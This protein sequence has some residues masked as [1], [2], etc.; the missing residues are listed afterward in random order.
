MDTP[1]P[2]QVSHILCPTDFSAEA[3]HALRYAALLADAFDA[4][5]TVLHVWQLPD[6]IRPDLS[7]AIEEG[8]AH[9][10]ESF[11]E[12]TEREARRRAETLL[13]SLAPAIKLRT[14][15]QIVP[16]N[17]AKVITEQAQALQCDLIVMGTHG[18][19]AM[20]HFV[21]GSV[22]EKVVRHASCPVLTARATAP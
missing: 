21:L 6:H 13:A 8:A 22:A 7:V 4:R 11:A 15:C 1:K 17:P 16:G 10:G 5:I 20:K 2:F 14:R 12:Y 9:R 18:W 19:T 3:E